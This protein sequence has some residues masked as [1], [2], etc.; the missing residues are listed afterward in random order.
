MH[1]PAPI[2]AITPSKKVYQD[3]QFSSGAEP[4]YLPNRPASWPAYVRSWL[5]QHASDGQFAIL[6]ERSPEGDHMM[7]VIS[8]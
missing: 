3:L 5:K 1:L 4:I 7:E 2:I 6:T 8:L